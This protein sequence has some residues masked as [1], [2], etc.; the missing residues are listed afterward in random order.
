MNGDA[1]FVE[2]GEACQKIFNQC[3][4]LNV[5]TILWKKSET[6][7]LSILSGADAVSSRQSFLLDGRWHQKAVDLVALG[8]GSTIKMS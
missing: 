1:T 5:D 2:I 6:H 8:K 7:S 4:F 3:G